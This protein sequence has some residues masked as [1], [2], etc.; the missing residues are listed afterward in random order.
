MSTVT[1]TPID[2]GP[3]APGQDPETGLITP[4]DANSGGTQATESPKTPETTNDTPPT[5]NAP[6]N[7]AEEGAVSRRESLE[8]TLGEYKISLGNLEDEYAKGNGFSDATYEKLAKAGFPRSIVDAY[9]SGLEVENQ[10]TAMMQEKEIT[11]VKALAGG[12]KGYGELLEW[13]KGN[14]T[15]EEIEGFN[16]ITATNNPAAIKAAVSGL[17]ARKQVQVGRDPNYLT[18]SAPGTTAADAY[19][20][21]AEVQRDMATDKYRTDEAFRQKVERKLAASNL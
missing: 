1:I 5:E 9:V 8:A 19:Q 14:L 20:S 13:A 12:D 6:K 11:A 18:G 3:L 7:A 21:W 15:V 4:Q 10:R 16:A 17:V 2:T